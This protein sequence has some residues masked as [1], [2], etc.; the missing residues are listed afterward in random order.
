MLA[1]VMLW[2]VILLGIWVLGDAAG[3]LADTLYSWWS[4]R[5]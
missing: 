4:K 2:V 1:F 3:H 5:K